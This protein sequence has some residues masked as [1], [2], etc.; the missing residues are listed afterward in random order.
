MS[1]YNK[2]IRSEQR[3]T[4]T[5]SIFSCLS[6]QSP[7]SCLMF[8]CDLPLLTALREAVLE[9]DV[10]VFSHFLFVMLFGILNERGHAQNVHSLVQQLIL[11]TSM[12][13]DTMTPHH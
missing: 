8:L 4:C 1:L 7:L 12:R 9:A 10:S 13:R 2:D 3:Y 5:I 11:T 6:S